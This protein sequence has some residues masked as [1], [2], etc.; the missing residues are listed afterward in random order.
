MEKET[1]SVQ[2]TFPSGNVSKGEWCDGKQNGFG[3]MTFGNMDRYEGGWKDGHMD[4][5][6]R[7]DFYEVK[8]DAYS[9]HYEGDFVQGKREGAGI[10]VYANKTRYE[11]QWQA[12]VRCGDGIAVFPNGDIYHGLW[13]EDKM[14]RGV[15]RLKNGDFYDGE[16]SN[17]KFEGFGHYYWTDGRWYEGSWKEGSMEDGMMFFPDG[18]YYEIKEGK[19]L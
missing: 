18:K 15:Y 7:Y 2:V 6:G 17:G 12:D 19:N 14:L 16:I 3:I 4:G 1:K 8:D 11:G 5:F 10:M 9:A 13:R